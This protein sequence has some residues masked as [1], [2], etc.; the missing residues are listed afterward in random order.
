MLETHSDEEIAKVI[1]RKPELV[2]K[3]RLQAPVRK[4]QHDFG[5]S[6]EQLHASHFWNNVKAQ[7]FAEEIPYFEQQWAKLVDQFSE[8]GIN[9]GDEM[10]LTDLILQVIQIDRYQMTI[11]KLETEMR[12]LERQIKDEMA[13]PEED[14]DLQDLQLW[15]TEIN[16]KRQSMNT[17]VNN[18]KSMKT[19]KNSAYDNLRMTRDARFKHA[20]ESK[21]NFWDM[22][23]ELNTVTSRK[24]EGRKNAL[25]KLASDVEAILL[26]QL[27]EFEDG[28]VDRPFL[29]PDLLKEEDERHADFQSRQAT[30]NVDNSEDENVDTEGGPEAAGPED[31]EGE[32][33]TS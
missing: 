13:K 33:E 17:F 16:Q 3:R 30:D 14:R 18:L 5:D 24:I 1:N 26:S 29:T 12:S 10:M 8:Q 21:V 23:K 31:E 22:L 20:E 28:E 25:A 19:L 2:A 6:I 9:A 32:E 7:L 4:L 15:H 27:M 11:K